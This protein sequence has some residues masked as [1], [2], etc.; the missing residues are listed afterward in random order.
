MS[1]LLA[2]CIAWF[3]MFGIAFAIA[4][5]PMVLGRWLVDTYGTMI[6]S[7]GALA[8]FAYSL[9]SVFKTTL[10][11]IAGILVLSE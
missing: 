1:D 3:T 5:L 9:R 6:A 7:I 10:A 2:K 8:L 11:G 4:F